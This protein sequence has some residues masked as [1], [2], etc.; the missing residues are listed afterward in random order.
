MSKRIDYIF[1]YSRKKK[2]ASGRHDTRVTKKKNGDVGIEQEK[3]KEEGEE[4][5]SFFK[6]I[7]VPVA[8]AA[9]VVLPVALPARYAIAFIPASS[10]PITNSIGAAT[11]VSGPVSLPVV[12]SSDGKIETYTRGSKYH[13]RDKR[14]GR[15]SQTRVGE[16]P[17]M[18]I[19]LSLC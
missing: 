14:E 17:H 2:C 6:T 13:G 11:V 1:G 10:S 19:L 7:P 12:P 16:G 5:E 8:P 18:L 4:L 3:E 15:R 9:N